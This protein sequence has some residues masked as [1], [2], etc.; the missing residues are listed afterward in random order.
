MTNSVVMSTLPSRLQTYFF[1]EQGKVREM[2]D[3]TFRAGN[4]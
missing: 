1:T 4:V 2:T 3:Y